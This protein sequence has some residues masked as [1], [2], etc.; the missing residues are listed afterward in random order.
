MCL[1]I[2]CWMVRK[3]SLYVLGQFKY[4]DETMYF[5]FPSV[6][7]VLCECTE[8]WKKTVV[9]DWA[10]LYMC[11]I[12]GVKTFLMKSL[13]SP[14][15]VHNMSSML[16]PYNSFDLFYAELQKC[17]ILLKIIIFFFFYN[18]SGSSEV[19]HARVGD[20]VEVPQCLFAETFK[21]KFTSHFRNFGLAWLM[22]VYSILVFIL[23]LTLLSFHEWNLW[24]KNSG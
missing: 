23:G 10:S 1:F 3:W 15:I 6:L 12:S 5:T 17:N 8:L 21:I 18:F 2:I 14:Y 13:P 24:P 11:C 9:L 22:K 7:N 4:L 20:S 19:H 16:Q